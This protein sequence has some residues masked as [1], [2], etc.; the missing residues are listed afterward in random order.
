MNDSVTSCLNA[1]TVPYNN[2]R[3]HIISTTTLGCCMVVNNQNLISILLYG[4]QTWW[5][6][7]HRIISSSTLSLL[8]IHSLTQLRVH[9]CQG[10][11]YYYCYCCILMLL[12]LL[13]WYYII[14]CEYGYV[15][16]QKRIWKHQHREKFLQQPL[17]T[18]RHSHQIS[19]YET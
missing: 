4:A 19:R 8:L 2:T 3:F 11:Y 18:S 13:L 1:S 10:F 17:H 7:S 15:R 12:L 9:S 6:I 5:Y 16:K 14:F